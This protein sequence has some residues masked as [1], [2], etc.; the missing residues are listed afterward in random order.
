MRAIRQMRYSTSVQSVPGPADA[1]RQ[2]RRDR[3]QIATVARERG[4][5]APAPGTQLQPEP[6]AALGEG[7]DVAAALALAPVAAGGRDQDRAAR[8]L[9]AG[10]DQMAGERMDAPAPP[11]APYELR[12]AV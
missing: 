12:L 11:A 7:Q 6:V 4:A 5:E 2:P 3:S 9:A 10:H 8:G 1:R